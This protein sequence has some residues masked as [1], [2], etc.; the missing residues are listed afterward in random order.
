MSEKDIR[1]DNIV[2]A[3]YPPF[4]YLI[5]M[6]AVEAGA[7]IYLLIKQTDSVNASMGSFMSSYQFFEN[8]DKRLENYTYIITLIAASMAVIVFGILF[9]RDCSVNQD[10][11]TAYR[12]KNV[13]RKDF[14]LSV[15][16]GFFSATGLSRLVYLLPLDD[17]IGSYEKVSSQL[18][19]GGIGIQ[20]VSLGIVVPIAEELIYRG[21]VFLRMK[22]IMEVWTAAVFAS[23]MFGLFHFN[24]LQGVYTFMLSMVLITVFLKYRSIIPC[25]IIH[26][27]AN[28]TAVLSEYYQISEAVNTGMVMYLL[29]MLLELFLM[30]ALLYDVIEG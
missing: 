21:L 22:K 1:F 20:L 9:I 5:M 29:V 8:L 15:G 14:F 3:L 25:I 30:G 17:V 11:L 4:L 23:V 27:M 24:L 10:F 2:K 13:K 6:L 18:L 12:W 26:S 19:K 28:I 16:I 7:D